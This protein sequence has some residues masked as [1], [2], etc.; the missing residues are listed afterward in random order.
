MN[1]RR[2]FLRL[3][4]AASVLWI[5]AVGFIGYDSVIVPRNKLSALKAA[6]A[7]TDEIIR[8]DVL[9]ADLI[10]LAHYVWMA[11]LPVVISFIL[12][13]AFAWVIAGFGRDDLPGRPEAIR[14]LV[15]QALER[16]G[17]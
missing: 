13:C 6:G 3:W 2:G 1:W 17:K 4:I 8:A 14:R 16:Q 10:P 11:L 15:E 9:F 5:G 12:G 7:S